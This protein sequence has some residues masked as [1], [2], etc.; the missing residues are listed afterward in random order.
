MTDRANKQRSRNPKASQE[1][2]LTAAETCFAEKGYAGTS[3]QDIANRAGVSRGTPSYFFGSKKEL[4]K[5]VLDRGFEAV[6]QLNTESAVSALAKQKGVKG[7]FTEVMNNY[8][9][10]LAANPNFVRLLQWESLTGKQLHLAN[11]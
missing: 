2:I 1:A 6:R 9:N 7:V 5:A 8:I 10:F 4:Y 11:P 3:I